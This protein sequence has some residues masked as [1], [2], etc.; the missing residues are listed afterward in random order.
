[1]P[2]SK[3]IT[4]ALD[5]LQGL[6]QGPLPGPVKRREMLVSVYKTLKQLQPDHL[7]ENT[8]QPGPLDIEEGDDL[9]L[10]FLDRG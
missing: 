6:I 3:E 8:K 9:D 10:P 2:T 1:M 5:I 4:D 7:L